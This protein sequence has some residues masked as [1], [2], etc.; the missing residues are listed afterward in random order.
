MKH[1]NF[2]GMLFTM[3]YDDFSQLDEVFK[4]HNNGGD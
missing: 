3:G 2:M 1:C 4:H